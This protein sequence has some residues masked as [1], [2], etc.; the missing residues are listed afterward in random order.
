M[1]KTP[2]TDWGKHQHE[3]YINLKICLKKTIDVIIIKAKIKKSVK[4]KKGDKTWNN[5]IINRFLY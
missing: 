4:N 1:Q 2:L 3:N 5:F